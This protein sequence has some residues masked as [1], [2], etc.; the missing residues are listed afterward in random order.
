M[1]TWVMH[2]AGNDWLRY[3]PWRSWKTSQAYLGIG[4]SRRGRSFSRPSL[5]A[6]KRLLW[7]QLNLNAVAKN[8]ILLIISQHPHCQYIMTPWRPFSI[9]SCCFQ[10]GGVNYHY[11]NAR[12]HPICHVFNKGNK[13]I[14]ILFYTDLTQ[15]CVAGK[16]GFQASL[17]LDGKILV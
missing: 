12:N 17:V 5:R 6:W 16:I 9:S 11:V 2:I 3:A 13:A 7:C 15:I 8:H 1:N 4:V 14:V 10:L